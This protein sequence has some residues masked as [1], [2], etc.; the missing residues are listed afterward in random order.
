MRK[1]LILLPLAMIGSMPVMARDMDCPP[2]PPPEEMAINLMADFDANSSLGLDANE[3]TEA[4]AFLYE[5]RPAPP[6]EANLPERPEPDHQAK[7]YRL[8]EKFDLDG[9][10]QLD[11]VELVEALASMHRHHG[12]PPRPRQ[13]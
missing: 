12:R 5:N 2:P 8:M 7:A 10:N 4:L 13:S 3:L 1:S 6:P 11:E 9:S